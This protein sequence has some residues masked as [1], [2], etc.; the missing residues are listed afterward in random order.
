MDQYQIDGAFLDGRM[1][2]TCDNAKHGC[3]VVNFEGKRVAGRDV[4]DGRLKAWRFYNLLQAR[5][6]YGEQHKSSLWDAP[7]CFF[8]HG[9]WEGEQFMNLKADGRKKLDILP[10]EGF[11]M[12]LN[13]F[14]YGLPTRFASYVE[15][16]FSA[17]ENCTYAFV[18]G[19]TWTQ[20]YR[21]NEMQVISPYWKAL[22]Q[23]GASNQHFLPYG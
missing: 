19:T 14:P 3:G 21:I 13:G 20:T 1:Y 8:W 18:H 4:W 12:L 16:P 15:Q 5:K 10:L 7:T 17:V 2:A 11:R 6:G 23:F 22:E 9:I